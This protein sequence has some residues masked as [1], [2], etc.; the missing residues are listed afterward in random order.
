M[1]CLFSYLLLPSNAKLSL[2]ILS[3]LISA[4]E[5]SIC[6]SIFVLSATSFFDI[7]FE[8]L[9]IGIPDKFSLVNWIS[10]DSET[11]L[12]FIYFTFAS[13]LNPVQLYF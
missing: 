4:S 13:T 9:S 10:P 2:T 8:R 11:V 3:K 1:S 5:K 6:K 7:L 12:S